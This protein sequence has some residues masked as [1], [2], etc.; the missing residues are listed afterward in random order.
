MSLLSIRTTLKPDIGASPS[1]LVYGEGLSI[2]GELLPATQVD[3]Q[4][5]RRLRRQQLAN[6]R[7]EVERL[8]PIPTSAH[9]QP[10]VHLPPNLDSATHVFVRRGGV[11]PT[12]ASPY[13]GPYRIAGRTPAGFNV[14]LPG[15]GI[16]EVALARVKPAFVEDEPQDDPQDLDEEIPPSPPPPGRPPGVRTRIPERTD[17]LTRFQSARTRTDPE[18]P[19]PTPAPEQANPPPMEDEPAPLPT[20]APEQVVPPPVEDEPAPSV[21]V[22]AQVPEDR[23]AR[24]TPIRYF[25]KENE[26]RFSRQ[27]PRINVNSFANAVFDHI[28]YPQS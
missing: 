18:T 20:P 10:Q 7:L 5:L 8:Q 23:S 6:L 17:R 28:G 25:S 9:R 13:E 3:D 16:E 22:A 2:P 1:D 19:Q 26:R 15:R 11:Q 4:E 27:R 21:P 12:L 14:H 24:Q